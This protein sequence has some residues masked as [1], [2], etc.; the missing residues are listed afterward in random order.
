MPR[1]GT[2]GEAYE[3]VAR[4]RRVLKCVHWVL[5]TLSAVSLLSL[6]PVQELN[7]AFTRGAGLVMFFRTIF[8]WAP[9]VI[10]GIYASYVLDGNYRGVLAFTFGALTATAIAIGLYLNV[11]ALHDKPPV[12]VI[13]V[14]VG[15]C[16]IA[17]ARLC[18]VIPTK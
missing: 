15:I 14:S 17:F 10:S 6:L 2:A 13:S 8:G 9:Y 11:F 1:R 3:S 18:A 5:G 4:A 16:L 7:T 12:I